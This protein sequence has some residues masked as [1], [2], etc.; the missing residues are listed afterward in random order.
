MLLTVEIEGERLR[1]TF[2]GWVVSVSAERVKSKFQGRRL[3]FKHCM[4]GQ[5]GTAG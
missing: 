2:F 4:I 1:V 5:R 3:L